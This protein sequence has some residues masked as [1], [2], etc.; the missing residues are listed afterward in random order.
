[1]LFICV[2]CETTYAQ[3]VV[4]CLECNDY[5]GLMPLADAKKTYDFLNEQEKN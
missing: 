2:F 1:M 5:K 3:D 4:I